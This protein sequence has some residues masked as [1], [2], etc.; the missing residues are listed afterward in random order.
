LEK[1][2]PLVFV[3]D[4]DTTILKLVC[5]ACESNGHEVYSDTM[6]SSV[7][8][9]LCA[10]RAAIEKQGGVLVCD[11]NMPG[12]PGEKFCQ[13]ILGHFDGLRILLYSGTDSASGHAVAARLGSAR[14]IAKADGLPNLL[15]QIESSMHNR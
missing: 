6:W 14:F 15:S 3:L 11:L 7:T 4:D 1:L 2:K 8:K 12:L 10:N 9:L 5:R 13:S